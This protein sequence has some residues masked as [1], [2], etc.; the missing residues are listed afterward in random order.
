MT[1][2]AKK[3]E[4]RAIVTYYKCHEEGHK[5]YKYQKDRQR[6]EEKED[7]LHYQELPLVHQIQLQE[8]EQ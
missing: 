5:S 6:C 1:H 3:L 2:M 4:K 7:E 8:Q